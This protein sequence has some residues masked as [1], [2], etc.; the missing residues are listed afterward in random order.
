MLS[1]QCV[2]GQRTVTL[3][4]DHLPGGNGRLLVEKTQSCEELIRVSSGRK[5]QN[6]DKAK[7]QVIVCY[8]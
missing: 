5:F 2:E 3:N 8:L 1:A 6:K 4:L 7:I